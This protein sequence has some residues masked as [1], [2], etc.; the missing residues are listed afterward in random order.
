MSLSLA[1]FRSAIPSPTPMTQRLIWPLGFL[2]L[3]IVLCGFG[4]VDSGLPSSMA[5]KRAHCLI[6][7]LA[8]GTLCWAVGGYGLR[9]LWPLQPAW[10]GAL[11]GL[12][13]GAIPAVAMQFMCMYAPLHTLLFHI[14]PA[15]ALGVVGA[16]VGRFA[17]RK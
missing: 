13:A 1:A 17:L 11:L 9:H 3:W 2:V 14:L 12:A 8:L 7:I 6:E 15:L 4:V 10:S 16:V 5:G